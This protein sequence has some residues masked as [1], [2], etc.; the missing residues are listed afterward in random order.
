[1]NE[2]PAVARETY[3]LADDIRRGLTF[4]ILLGLLHFVVLVFVH[5]CLQKTLFSI[6][7]SVWGLIW[8]GT[9]IPALLMFGSWALFGVA[10]DAARGDKKAIMVLRV[11]IA[12]IDI[13]TFVNIFFAIL[14][15]HAAWPLFFF[16]PSALGG[17]FL[18][19]IMANE[20]IN[21]KRWVVFPLINILVAVVSIIYQGRKDYEPFVPAGSSGWFHSLITSG[22]GNLW[23]GPALIVLALVLSKMFGSKSTPPAPPA[24]SGGDH[25]A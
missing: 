10:G 13:E 2:G 22:H 18:T 16:L 5:A 24:S 1:M 17:Y 15:F 23:L 25:H 20:S 21:W 6:A 9:L 4:A 14:P 11:V 8:V 7:N 19:R 12:F 3:E